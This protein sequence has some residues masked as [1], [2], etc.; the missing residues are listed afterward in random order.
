MPLIERYLFRQLLG[1]TLLA[2]AALSG[3]AILSQS[4]AALDIL[5]DQRQ[6][7]LVFA[8]ITLLAMPQLIVMILPVAVFVAALVAFNRLHTEQEIVICFAGGMSRWRVMSPALRLAGLVTLFSLLLTLWVQPYSYRA[9]RQTLQTV[10]ADLA[11]TMIR[12]GRF[13]HPAPGLTV[14]AQSTDDAGAFHN[15]FIHQDTGKGRATT[16][17][18]REGLIEKRQGAPVL[19]MK[20]GATQEFSKTGVL[21]Y[22]SFDEYVFD[23][24]GLI[25]VDKAI[26]YKASDRYLHELFFPDLR[27]EWERNN[28]KKMLAE[29]HSRLASPLYNIAFMLMALAAVIGGS[30]SKMGYAARMTVAGAAALL[31]RTLGF[32]VQ[33]GATANPELNILQYLLPIAAGLW[34]VRVLFR[35]PR[36]HDAW[37]PALWR[38]VAEAAPA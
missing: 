37:P 13:T 24:R 17:T 4:L 30:F 5:V 2:I 10:R 21:N 9:M 34:A 16:V 38:A 36:K 6:S 29:A 12:P 18:A 27:G 32:A 8:R 33:S 3:V 7:P 28:R 15:L 22:L 25:Q 26:T 23:L 19:V 20:H 11:A 35:R 31:A 14:Y 1:P